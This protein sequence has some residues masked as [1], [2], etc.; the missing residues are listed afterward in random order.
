MA[1]IHKLQAG[2]VLTITAGADR[3]CV[4]NADDGSVSA[5]ISST[6]SQTFGPYLVERRF[7]V[8][9]GATA[10]SDAYSLALGGLLTSNAGA[11]VTAVAASANV[12]PTGD[13]NGLTFTAKT[14]GAAGNNISVRYV[15][16]GSNDAALSVYVVGTAI[17]VSLATG[18]AGAITSTAAEIKAAVDASARA[19]SLVSVAVYTAD[20]G[21]ADDGS[22]VVT[23][24][25]LANLTSG[26]GTGIGA[27]LPGA[28]CIDTTNSD[29]YRN[30]G[31]T[32]APVW[33]KIG[34]A[35]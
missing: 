13:D 34:D 32:A 27:V 10:S 18:V 20:A 3:A 19:S 28:L 1:T 23:A 4:Q 14:Y 35:A 17:T 33:V 22:G 16:P 2:Y 29:V 31:T 21:V 15:D 8:S 9:D 24:M 26:A 5:F 7:L 6:F 11:P 12:N 25:A 30:D